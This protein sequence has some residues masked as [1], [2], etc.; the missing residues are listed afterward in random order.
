M[1]V[2]AGHPSGLR[3]RHTRDGCD[4]C[5]GF[6]PP[7]SVWRYLCTYRPPVGRYLEAMANERRLPNGHLL[8]LGRFEA[9]D[10][11][12]GDGMVE[13]APGDEGYEA[14]DAYLPLDPTATDGFDSAEG[15]PTS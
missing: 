13:M 12:A 8:V 5:D 3:R 1:A 15:R 6:A 9:P 2:I 4:D 7:P 10:G 14:W 11:T